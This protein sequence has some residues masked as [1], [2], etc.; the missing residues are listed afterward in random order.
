[1]PFGLVGQLGASGRRRERASTM[2]IG[3]LAREQVFEERMRAR[4]RLWFTTFDHAVEC[5]I[6]MFHTPPFWHC[7]LA[8]LNLLQHVCVKQGRNGLMGTSQRPRSAVRLNRQYDPA[9]D[10]DS[11]EK[12][13]ERPEIEDDEEASPDVSVD[14]YSAIEGVYNNH[15]NDSQGDG[16]GE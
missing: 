12:D 5:Q 13:S 16:D 6:N 9:A 3:K 2:P 14:P 10:A 7:V 1:M 11:E 4:V 8:N 15:Q